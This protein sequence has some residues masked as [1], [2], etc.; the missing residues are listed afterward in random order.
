[1][2]QKIVLT[3][4]LVLIGHASLAV[5]STEAT[6]QNNEEVQQ[7]RLE[8][9][10][11]KIDY[12]DALLKKDIESLDQNL[13]NTIQEKDNRFND[14]SKTLTIFGTLISLLVATL[15]F[16]AFFKA[17]AVARE[18]AEKWIED[19][20]TKLQDK[21]EREFDS[22]ITAVQMQIEE[23]QTHLQSAKAHTDQIKS[24]ADEVS[25]IKE[26]MQQG[27]D[28]DNTV[29]VQLTESEKNVLQSEVDLLRN[30]PESQYTYNDWRTR[31]FDAFDN[32]NFEEALYFINRSL[33]VK[34]INEL[35][36]IKSLVNKGIAL[37]RLY[38]YKESIEAYDAVLDRY[39]DSKE[40]VLQ[41]GVCKAMFNKGLA[42]SKLYR[43]EEAEIVY[44]TVLERYVGSTELALQEGVVRAMINKG[45]ILGNRGLHQEAIAVYDEV[46]DHYS[47][48]KELMLQE[49]AARALVSKGIAFDK[50]GRHEEAIGVYNELLDRYSGSTDLVLLERV[51]KALVNKGIALGELG[52][53]EEA[54]TVYD[55]LLQRYSGSTELVLQE[56]VAKATTYKDEALGILNNR[57]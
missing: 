33:Q 47:G 41:E 51:A 31:M 11:N 26:K 7:L 53:H 50:L 43:Y 8:N 36:F 4:S 13:K 5:A 34:S 48:S 3:V 22:K 2:F 49:G 42:L 21:I 44:N 9:L 29:D 55:D 12:G 30:K 28:N 40:L 35:D 16:F 14:V 6:S 1:M 18:E 23:I 10:A 57:A 45:A 46:L 39:L 38:R 37:S 56:L 19:N 52:R 54:I 27:M 15:A 25:K 17:K 24:H 20:K 32:N